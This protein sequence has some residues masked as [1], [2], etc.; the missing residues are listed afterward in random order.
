MNARTVTR[1]DKLAAD[2]NAKSGSGWSE[3]LEFYIGQANIID[4][5][6]DV[7][8][9]IAIWHEL[10][11]GGPDG[12]ASIP[13]MFGEEPELDRDRSEALKACFD[14]CFRDFPV[15]IRDMWL[16]RSLSNAKLDVEHW[17][18]S[19][20]VRDPR[21][22]D[23]ALVHMLDRLSQLG[24]H[25]RTL[26]E[27]AWYFEGRREEKKIAQK[28]PLRLN[29]SGYA[30]ELPVF[31]SHLMAADDNI[32]SIG[33]LGSFECSVIGADGDRIRICEI[34]GKLFW[35]ARKDVETNTSRCANVLRQHRNRR[36]I[37]ENPEL[38]EKMRQDRRN[39]YRQRKKL[40]ML[41]NGSG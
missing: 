32:I 22:Y 11:T 28:R 26:R 29:R 23:L 33:A 16:E 25:R 39:N 27:I 41:A 40:E 24:E 8:D 30:D 34:C 35:A 36:S 10:S 19:R 20:P 15:E 31:D 1:K 5:E 6:A 14:R 13:F 7:I 37:R 3:D 21:I 4:A 17:E 2:K 18:S 12:F 9:Y 38:A